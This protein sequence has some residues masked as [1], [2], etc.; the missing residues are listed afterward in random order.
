MLKNFEGMQLETTL[1]R[2]ERDLREAID[3]TKKQDKYKDEA[4]KEKAKNED[5]KQKKK[6]GGV[7]S[8]YGYAPE[9][10]RSSALETDIGDLS[11][12]DSDKLAILESI[13]KS[14]DTA[15]VV[16]E[17]KAELGIV[18]EIT[19][20][21]QSY[22][23]EPLSDEF[24]EHADVL[25]EGSAN[26]AWVAKR[27]EGLIPK[28]YNIESFENDGTSKDESRLKNPYVIP[29]LFSFSE[30]EEEDVKPYESNI[31][32]LLGEEPAA[33]NKRA[34]D[35]EE[36]DVKALLELAKNSI[37]NRESINANGEAAENTVNILKLE[38]QSVNALKKRLLEAEEEA[39]R[40]IQNATQ[41]AQ[42]MRASV[43]DQVNRQI[44]K[45]V[46]DAVKAAEEEGYKKGFEKGESAGLLRAKEMV[47]TAMQEEAAEFRESLLA[48]L[49]NFRKTQDGILDKYL[50]DLTDLAVDIAEKV[51]KISLKSS[52]DVVASMIMEAAETC[53]N[54]A[55][56]KVYIS[57]D[58]KSIAVNLE[59]ELI[60]A[61][62][63]IS[64]NVK[65]V[66]MEDEPSGT[67]IIETPDQRI[68][69][70]ADVQIENIRQLV[71]ENK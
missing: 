29:D 17:E 52:K 22:D 12:I 11:D 20:M 21:L 24:I 27:R 46:S 38:K 14:R 26:H 48:D 13:K 44:A 3:I 7:K 32:M 31:D 50:D 67:C 71:E 6:P 34:F 41:E 33:E 68:D 2:A 36:L 8:L 60:D 53:R 5:K 47:N 61:L 19:S 25:T 4:P 43:Q 45:Q 9:L 30:L 56:A 23:D 70:S 39:A 59:K 28:D 15:G 1:D 37:E 16:A 58:D 42:E 49:E 18:D 51:V 69:A 40:I 35:S 65:V 54:K 63:Q 10:S 55:W 57:N 66:I 62:S 64:Q